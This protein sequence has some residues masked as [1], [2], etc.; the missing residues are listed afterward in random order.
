MLPVMNASP[1]SIEFT[2]R[3]QR[4]AAVRVRLRRIDARWLAEIS[5]PTSSVGVGGSARQALTAALQPLGDIE[6]R[7]LLADL[8]LLEPSVAV[9]ALEA[10]ARSA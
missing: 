6:T 2:L 10:D 7:L 4:T 1:G 9:L 3:P 5:S 8:G